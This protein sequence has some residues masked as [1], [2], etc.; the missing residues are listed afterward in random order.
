NDRLHFIQGSAT[1]APDAQYDLLLVLDVMEHIEDYYSFLRDLRSK[2]R[3][4][5]LHIPLELSAQTVLRSQGL[6]HTQTAYGHLHYFTRETALQALQNA[7]Y[8]VVD[9]IYT[10]R[11][12]EEPTTELP[13]RLMRLPRTLLFAANEH[14]AARLFGGFSLLVLATADVEEQSGQMNGLVTSHI[15]KSE[16]LSHDTSGRDG[17]R[18][19]AQH[20][21]MLRI[22]P[23]LVTLV[24]AS[25]L[26]AMI[27]LSAQVWRRIV[28]RRHEP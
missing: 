14:L 3:H 11:A 19:P 18:A 2:G 25:V 8:T 5:M 23:L 13:R 1:D 21:T 6:L 28:T 27:G 16:R 22:R 17:I 15:P 4:I 12:L 24:C 7:G 9:A 10:R 26:L 20:P